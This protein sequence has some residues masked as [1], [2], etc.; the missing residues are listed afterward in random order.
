MLAKMMLGLHIRNVAEDIL[1]FAR[2]DAVNRAKSAFQL[3]IRRLGRVIR[4]ITGYVGSE[5]RKEACLCRPCRS[6]DDLGRIL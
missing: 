6:I 1:N 2:L 5:S 3:L 4:S